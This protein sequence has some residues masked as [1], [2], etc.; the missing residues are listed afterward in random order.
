MKL[1]TENIATVNCIVTPLLYM[2]VLLPLVS[3]FK[4][5][6]MIFPI[7]ILIHNILFWSLVVY[8]EKNK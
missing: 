6:M 8:S 7:T 1:D 4:V 3:F 5:N 2:S